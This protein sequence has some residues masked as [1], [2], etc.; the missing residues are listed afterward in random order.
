M[1]NI[2]YRIISYDPQ[3][4]GLISI[5]QKAVADLLQIVGL[6]VS[7]ESIE[8]EG[9]EELVLE[10]DQLGLWEKNDDI[11]FR[12]R[13]RAI[14]RKAYA[15]RE[16]GGMNKVLLVTSINIGSIVGLSDEWI[17]IVSSC[18]INDDPDTVTTAIYHELGHIH[19]I[20]D[21]K[22]K[23]IGNYETAGIKDEEIAALEYK[24]QGEDAIFYWRGEH[25]L[26][27]GCSMRQRLCFENWKKHL[28]KERLLGKP[29]CD[30]CVA[31]LKR[32]VEA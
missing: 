29:Y 8:C 9:K 12:W 5:T 2:S 11:G 21:E 27:V 16:D 24:Y 22:R 3:R 14:C 19:G 7:A 17:A 4:I 28:T 30:K 1:K 26:N 23:N 20:P 18:R 32:M 25:C 31:D 15:Q 10:W 6:K 13:M